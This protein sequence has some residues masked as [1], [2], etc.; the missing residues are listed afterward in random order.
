MKEKLLSIT[1]GVHPDEYGVPVENPRRSKLPTFVER[2]SL[3]YTYADE[4]QAR[5]LGSQVAHFTLQAA[6]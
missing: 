1:R 5:G 3:D 2:S 6:A 4:K